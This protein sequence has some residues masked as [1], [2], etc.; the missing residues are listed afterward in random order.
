MLTIPKRRRHKQSTTTTVR[1]IQLRGKNLFI[2][3]HF[4]FDSKYLIK[5]KP[6]RAKKECDRAQSQ[7]AHYENGYECEANSIQ[8]IRIP[9]KFSVFFTS[10][11]NC[12]EVFSFSCIFGT[13][14]GHLWASGIPKVQIALLDAIQSR[15]EFPKKSLGWNSSHT[16]VLCTIFLFTRAENY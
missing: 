15:I 2:G 3:F 4:H 8:S 7:A 10:F 16:L 12:F 11:S 6:E 9:G 14:L 5:Q 13:K 1:W